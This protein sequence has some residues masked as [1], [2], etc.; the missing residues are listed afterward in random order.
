MPQRQKEEVR[1][2][3]ITSSKLRSV[4]DE[5]PRDLMAKHNSRGGGLTLF[6]WLESLVHEELAFFSTLTVGRLFTAMGFLHDFLQDTAKMRRRG[7]GRSRCSV[8]NRRRCSHGG[9]PVRVI[10][11]AVMMCV[12]RALVWG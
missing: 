3:S 11:G 1:Q 4:K 2:T 6:V 12:F 8:T 9:G 5:H 7:S 10:V